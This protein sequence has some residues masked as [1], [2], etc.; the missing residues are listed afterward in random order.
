ML[1]KKVDE[2]LTN[3]CYMKSVSSPFVLAEEAMKRAYV[4]IKS[5]QAEEKGFINVASEALQEIGEE[6]SKQ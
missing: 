1:G 4:L 6:H 3:E 5:G 2:S